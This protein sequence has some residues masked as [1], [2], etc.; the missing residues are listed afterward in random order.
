[1][2]THFGR[3]LTL[4]RGLAVT[5]RLNCLASSPQVML[6]GQSLEILTKWFKHLTFFSPVHALHI[7]VNLHSFIFIPNLFINLFYVFTGFCR[8]VFHWTVSLTSNGKPRPCEHYF[9]SL[10]LGFTLVRLSQS[11]LTSP[12]ITSHLSHLWYAT[13]L[14]GWLLGL[15]GLAARSPVFGALHL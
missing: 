12:H 15:A 13:W 2:S 4:L 1:M 7:L 10:Q 3:Y 5:K 8:R 6:Q 11:P 14:S 9:C